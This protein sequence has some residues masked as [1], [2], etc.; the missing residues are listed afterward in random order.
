MAFDDVLIRTGYSLAFLLLM[1]LAGY[2]ELLGKKK[3]SK[4]HN[5]PFARQLNSVVKRLDNVVEERIDRPFVRHFDTSEGR[6]SDFIGQLVSLVAQFAAFAV[7]TQQ[8]PLLLVVAGA[9]VFLL[10]V[11]WRELVGGIVGLT[12]SEKESKVF[13]LNLW[14]L[15]SR[16]EVKIGKILAG[17]VYI[18][19]ISG[20]L[21]VF[22]QHDIGDVNALPWIAG[23]QFGFLWTSWVIINAFTYWHLMTSEY[24]DNDARDNRLLE[25]FSN[26]IRA[27][28]YLIYPYSLVLDHKEG[29]ISLFFATWLAIPF[30]VFLTLDMV[31]F[32]IGV[33]RHRARCKQLA[34]WRYDWLS[35]T[36]AYIKLPSTTPQRQTHLDNSAH[37]L[38][39]EIKSLQNRLE[40]RNA[41]LT[42]DF[43]KELPPRCDIRESHLDELLEWQDVM[44]SSQAEISDY[45]EVRQKVAEKDMV[46]A[47]TLSSNVGALFS[48]ALAALILWLFTV[49]EDDI[50]DYLRNKTDRQLQPV[51]ETS[52]QAPATSNKPK[53]GNQ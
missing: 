18:V 43:I 38:E 52:E 30:M 4:K 29:W 45:F 6:A 20:A 50:K 25:A 53:T 5:F 47:E 34:T 23:F 28:V 42:R 31:P 7:L 51:T 19:S 24:L 39:S 44:L 2:S 14:M 46:K 10:S 16:L 12:L 48:G 11:I 22:W 32:F 49:Y 17:L 13:Q 27:T 9:L 36:L 37:D 33:Y 15:F 40:K 35:R 8:F 1:M 3:S 21:V 26:A 41:R